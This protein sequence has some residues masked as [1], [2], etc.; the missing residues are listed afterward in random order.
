M[1]ILVLG[2]SGFVGGHL[3]RRLSRDGHRLR[4][5]TRYAPGARRLAILPGVR[6]RPFDPYDVDR[7]TAEAE[8]CDAVINLVGH[9][10]GRD[11]AA[12]RRAHVEL[13]EI[14]IEACRRAGVARFVQM[15]AVGA[16]SDRSHS[17]ATRGAGDAR[18]MES[19]LEWT[20]LRSS[21][22]FGPDDRFLRRFSRLLALFP[23]LPLA[24]ADA[25]L[26]PVFVG[27]V[28]EAFA[29]VLPR[30][31]AVAAS[32]ELCGPERWTL[33]EVAE[34][35][36]EQRALRRW[37]I[38]MP[39]LLGRLQAGIF[40]WLPGNLYSTDRF[41]SLGAPGVCDDDGFA[42]LDVV[43]WSMRDK[44]TEWLRPSARQ[45]RFRRFREVAGRTRGANEP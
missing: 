43:P 13:V 16:G 28:A 12:Y 9:D 8:G 6:I 7:L 45:A 34:F 14:A 25:V 18:V 39:D 1:D 40:D 32:Y 31:D 11:L 21:T 41:R 38:G 44:A 35:V 23:V 42:R 17:L 22:I 29:R 10:R 2:G 19:G 27:D 33:R 30:R 3:A 37:V 15:S 36:A 20:L 24:R 4:I 5:G 26:T